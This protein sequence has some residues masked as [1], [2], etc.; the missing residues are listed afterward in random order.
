MR[1]VDTV[2]SYEQLHVPLRQRMAS[3]GLTRED[4]GALAGVP[5]GYAGKVF[6]PYPVRKIGID[7]WVAFAQAAGLRLALVEDESLMA[8]I[9]GFRSDP[10]PL[11]TADKHVP[12]EI[13]EPRA[14]LHQVLCQQLRKHA[15]R[16]SKKAAIARK[17]IRAPT[18]RRIAKHAAR[19][20][21]K[22]ERQRRK[23]QSR[24]MLAK[25][26]AS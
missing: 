17:K 21:W 26:P 4:V 1:V 16:A 11:R 7:L 23:A 15:L 12:D 20:R 19:V 14:L 13:L 2:T 3:L 24:S 5:D 10:V 6:A 9:A 22:R 8:R 25:L 18:R